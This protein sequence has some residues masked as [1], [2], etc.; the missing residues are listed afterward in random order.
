MPAAREGQVVD[1]G[2]GPNKRRHPRFVVEGLVGRVTT[3]AEVTI[4]NLSLSG[5]AVRTA[6]RLNIGREYTLRLELG[7]ANVQ[8]R[9][10]VVWSVLTG[11]KPDPSGESRP[12]YSAGL[13]FTDVLNERLL[14]IMQFIDQHQ[15]YEEKRLGGL[16]F[17][18]DGTGRGLLG[19][20]DYRVKLISLSGMLI[21]AA[22]ELVVGSEHAMELA[23]EG[24]SPLHFTGRVAPYT[25]VVQE[26]PRRVEI[27]VEFVRFQGDG[28]DRLR[29]FVRSLAERADDRRPA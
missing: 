29:A 14:G 15:V 12:Q 17:Q 4:L 16:R 27:G 6:Q 22:G 9:C 24:E 21:E 13:R 8:V 18:I 25:R 1:G 23:P 20:P 26:E 10:A 5:A 28:E 7:S 11:L 3:V 19:Q 2:S